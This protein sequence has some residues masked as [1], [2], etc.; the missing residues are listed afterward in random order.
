MW[1]ISSTLSSSWN[2]LSR[3][4]GVYSVLQHLHP[5]LALVFGPLFRKNFW[6]SGVRLQVKTWSDRSS[7]WFHPKL[8]ICCINVFQSID[9]KQRL[10]SRKRTWMNLQIAWS[11]VFPT[12]PPFLSMPCSNPAR[13]CATFLS[14]SFSWTACS[15]NADLRTPLFLPHRRIG[16]GC[17]RIQVPEMSELQKKFQKLTSCKPPSLLPFQWTPNLCAYRTLH[18]A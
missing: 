10:M 11:R 6:E 5:R 17:K 14:L 15:L 16:S 8:K 7:Q 3:R 18:I 13:A 2:G 9:H 12:R 4:D 1:H